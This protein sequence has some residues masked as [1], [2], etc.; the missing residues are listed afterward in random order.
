MCD[1]TEF[2]LSSRTPPDRI[3]EYINHLMTLMICTAGKHLK[4]SIFS[5][6]KCK[7]ANSVLQ[8]QKNF[9][10][11]KSQG[12]VIRFEHAT[13]GIIINSSRILILQM[14]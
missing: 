3:F 14:Y 5:D 13:V 10:L 7:V 6:R 1:R 12:S 4:L 8:V 9:P 2:L 11:L